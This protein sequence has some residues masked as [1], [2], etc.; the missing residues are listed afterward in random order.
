[1]KKECFA[2]KGGTECS[3][4]EENL[5][6]TKGKCKFFATNEMVARSVKKSKDILAKKGLFPC[7][8]TRIENG[9]KTEVQSVSRTPSCPQRNITACC[10]SLS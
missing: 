3:A 10:D 4:L 2:N 6:E 1:M 8:K 9:G 7:L 5:C